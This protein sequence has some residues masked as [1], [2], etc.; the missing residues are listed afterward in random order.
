MTTSYGLR[1][2]GQGV[3]TELLGFWLL[4]TFAPSPWRALRERPMAAGALIP[5]PPQ[6]NTSIT[7][8]SITPT[9]KLSCTKQ[10]L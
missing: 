6:T 4:T 10:D 1:P 7:P 8:S 5:N 9:P 3:V 2:I